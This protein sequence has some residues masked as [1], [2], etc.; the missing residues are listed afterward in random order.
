VTK[1]DP[2]DAIWRRAEIDSPCVK[3]C[4]IHPEARLCIGCHRTIEEIAAWSRLTPEDRRAIMAELPGRAPNLAQR[5]GGRA[6]RL[7]RS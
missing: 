5:R 7:S 1:P 2:S 6:A 3:V 4:V